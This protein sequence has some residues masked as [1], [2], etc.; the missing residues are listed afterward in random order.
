VSAQLHPPVQSGL[1]SGLSVRIVSQL[2][3][4]SRG[5]HV[6]GRCGYEAQATIEGHTQIL[7][8]CACA[9]RYGNDDLPHSDKMHP[10]NFGLFGAK[11]CR[12]Q[13]CGVL[14]SATNRLRRWLQNHE[15]AELCPA[16]ALVTLVPIP[17]FKVGV[18]TCFQATNTV[19]N[20]LHSS[21]QLQ[22]PRNWLICFH[23]L[24]RRTQRDATT[25]H[26]VT[27]SSQPCRETAAYVDTDR[28]LGWEAPNFL[29]RQGG[30]RRVILVSV[31]LQNDFVS[32][33]GL[34]RHQL[35]RGLM[36]H[37]TS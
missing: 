25:L 8:L 3:L 4:V 23:G 31:Q 27:R 20:N 22:K 34:L 16:V 1:A 35:Q 13:C 10:A 15:M 32:S 26:E 7:A 17:D 18:P 11:T 28:Y 37:P 14:E 6:P 36:L 33:S 29:L 9:A 12:F 30:Q 5:S 21:K 2:Y 24:L 19:G